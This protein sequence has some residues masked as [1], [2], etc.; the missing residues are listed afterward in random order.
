MDVVKASLVCFS[1]LFWLSGLATLSLGLWARLALSIYLEEL[2]T[3]DYSSAPYV[4]LAAGAAVTAWGF[5]GCF[6]AATGNPRLLRVYGLFQVAVLVAGLAAGLSGLFYRRD[7]A[8]GFRHGL[9]RALRL[10]G[11]DDAKS[12]AMDGLQRALDCCGVDGFQDWLPA[13]WSRGRLNNGS[14]PESC[15]V[16]RRGCRSDPVGPAGEG[17]FPDGCFTKLVDLVSDNLFYIACGAL[18]LA[19]TQIIGIAL[20]CVL[21]ARIEAGPG[22]EG[23]RDTL[24]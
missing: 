20:A 4:L 24:S 18:G 3:G 9:A 16:R 6:S 23:D 7:I 21:A 15:C 5:L 11:D 13:P 12:A 2:T 19:F 1:L 17:I 22:P 8:E 14:V 10:Y